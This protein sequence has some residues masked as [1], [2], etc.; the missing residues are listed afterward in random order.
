M[1]IFSSKQY[2]WKDITIVIGGRILEGVTEVEYT[3]KQEKETLRGRGD[4]GLAILRG[5]KDFDG[6]LTIWQSEL[7][8]M[9]QD[10][11]NKDIL[12]LNFDVVISYIPPE[13]G[14]PVIDIMKGC[15]FTEVK[16]GM[17]QGDKN[18]LIELPIIFLDVKRQ[19]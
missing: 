7:E 1:A 9:V 19:Q 5:N 18:M 4:K 8:A 16:K 14:I 11:P 13:I 2:A 15:E 17:K 10:S 12:A 6:K 3:E